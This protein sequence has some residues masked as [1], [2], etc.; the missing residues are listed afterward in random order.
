MTVHDL[1]RPLW[2]DETAT[3]HP[4]P[5]QRRGT[6]V[7]GPD[8]V[9]NGWL[10]YA[11]SRLIRWDLRR[12]EG[13]GQ[14]GRTV[15]YATAAANGNVPAAA[16]FVRPVWLR[17]FS[18]PFDFSGWAMVTAE[19]SHANAGFKVAFLH[20]NNTSMWLAQ[21]L[22]GNRVASLWQEERIG[23]Q[24]PGQDGKSWV[25]PPF[26]W[27]VNRVYHWTVSV[28]PGWIGVSVDDRQIMEHKPAKMASS[29][30]VGFRLDKAPIHFGGLVVDER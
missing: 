10:N 29:G 6:V 18:V 24:L 1:D 14:D 19:P 11:S 16:N 30:Q 3:L 23:A 21:I 13:H 7:V 2:D 26:Q 17:N 28:R 27:D 25:H 4:D 20:Q 15:H 5:R 9:Q 12:A 22:R 8:R